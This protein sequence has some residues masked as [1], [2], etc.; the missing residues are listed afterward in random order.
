MFR[1]FSLFG[2]VLQT[3]HVKACIV[4]GR[5]GG[6]QTL[7]SHYWVSRINHPPPFLGAPP[8]GTLGDDDDDDD[9]VFIM[10]MVMVWRWW[11][12][13]WLWRWLRWWCW[14]WTSRLI[15]LGSSFT[16]C[17]IWEA[18]WWWWWWWW[19]WCWRWTS[20]LIVPPPAARYEM[21]IEMMIEVMML[22]WRWKSQLIVPPP[23]ARYERRPPLP[24]LKFHQAGNVC[25]C[26]VLPNIHSCP[27]LLLC[28]V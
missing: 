12:R 19:W 23:A 10:M 2:Q 5:G 15:A 20:Q 22:K 16:S 28:Q 11:S 3:Q 14:R 24:L 25:Q 21:M 8:I 13:W 9:L 27:Q 4:R 7:R 26:N 1:Y 6:R 17:Q 18:W